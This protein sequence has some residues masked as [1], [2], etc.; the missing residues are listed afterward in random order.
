MLLV[1]GAVSLLALL[2]PLFSFSLHCFSTTRKI[3]EDGS[4]SEEKFVCTDDDF[5]KEI[6]Y[7]KEKVDAG[8][9]FIITQMFFDIPVFAAFVKACRDAGITVPIVPGIMCIMKYGGFVRMTGLCK[10]RV[11]EDVWTALDKIKD[12]AKAV[13][14][15]VCFVPC[16][17]CLP[18]SYA[19]RLTLINC[20]FFL[21]FVL[22]DSLRR[23][24][25]AIQIGI[26]F[27]TII[28]VAWIG[29]FCRFG[30]E[31]GVKLCRELLKTGLVKGLHFYTLNLTQC[32]YAILKGLNRF[33][34]KPFAKVSREVRWLSFFFFHHVVI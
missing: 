5:A 4:T 15:Y 28:A 2:T 12:D 32:V 27:L 14:E 34:E 21:P 23:T 3:A 11:P 33:V 17:P 18:A 29:F 6:A 1:H 7:L 22:L 8:A 31:F 10:S 25:S 19:G 16:L 30:V 26:Y 9:D 20:F 24:V 13:K